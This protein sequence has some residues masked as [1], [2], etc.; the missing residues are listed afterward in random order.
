MTQQ[1]EAQL[2][3]VVVAASAMA[4]R[5][6]FVLCGSDPSHLRDAGET[7]LE[8]ILDAHARLSRFERTSVVA[9]INQ[10]AGRAPVRIDDEIFD[11]LALCE[12]IRMESA[13]AFDICLGTSALILDAA[14]RTAMLQEP[15]GAID[16]GGVGK[17]HALDLAAATLRDAGVASALLHGGTSTIAAIGARPDGQPWSVRIAKGFDAQLADESLSVSNAIEGS[18]AQRRHITGSSTTTAAAVIHTSAAG[19]DAW[20]TALVAGAAAHPARCARMINSTWTRSK[21]W[22]A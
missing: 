19:A 15:S 9:A 11:L 12:R 1:V 14:A 20:S 13:N 17:G 22:H 8:D 16:L 10:S 7:A 4:T 21:D 5:F 3:T 6:E 18:T 2:E